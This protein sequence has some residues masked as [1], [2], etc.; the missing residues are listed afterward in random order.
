M[1][2]PNIPRCRFCPDFS[3]K[4]LLK[5]SYFNFEK[6]AI[7]VRL[8]EKKL[9]LKNKFNNIFRSLQKNVILNFFFFWKIEKSSFQFFKIL[10]I[11][12]PETDAQNDPSPPHFMLPSVPFEQ[13][14]VVNRFCC[15]PRFSP[16]PSMYSPHTFYSPIPFR[17]LSQ[18]RSSASN[19]KLKIGTV[20]WKYLK[21]TLKI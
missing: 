11:I 13:P 16:S 9:Y 5:N 14:D 21:L 18:S 15:P 12:P 6:L 17:F 1:N 10:Q 3:S 8:I 20:N 4:K 2:S 19:S 7:V